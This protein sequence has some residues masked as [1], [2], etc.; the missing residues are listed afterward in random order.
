MKLCNWE[1]SEK[2][3][4]EEAEEEQKS[5]IRFIWLAHSHFL[6]DGS[7][8][9]SV[10]LKFFINFP[11]EDLYVLDIGL[12]LVI[13]FSFCNVTWV[14]SFLSSASRMYSRN[15]VSSLLVLIVLASTYGWIA[16]RLGT[17][18]QQSTVSDLKT[19]I[20]LHSLKTIISEWISL[21]QVT[22]GMN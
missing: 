11:H 19:W 5:Q 12:P 20:F 8:S 15:L 18:M 6:L 3:R 14:S 7:F 17:G 4:Q 10:R 9:Y 2:D 16:R 21:C 22:S 13:K 1:R